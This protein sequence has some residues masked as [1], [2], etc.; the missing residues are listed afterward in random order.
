MIASIAKEADGRDWL[1]LSMSH[2]KRVPNY[3]ELVYLKKH[4]AGE[5]RKAIMVLPASEEHV[6]IHPNVLHLFVCIS[7]DPLPDFS[8][9][10]P[11]GRRTL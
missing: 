8:G 2:R 9:F 5:N 7:G 10:L 11:D 3:D 1:H 6:N 4:W